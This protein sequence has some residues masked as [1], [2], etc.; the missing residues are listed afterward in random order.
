LSALEPGLLRWPAGHR[1]QEYVWSRGGGGQSG[2]WMLT[3]EHI[4]AFIHLAR[5]TGAEP[6]F[7]INIKRSTP[8]AAADLLHFLHVEHGYG[9]RWLQL[10]NEPDLRDNIFTSPEAY[11]DVL[12]SFASALR[13][14]DPSARF[15]GP[16][17][18]TGAHVGAIHGT[19]DWMTPILSRVGSLFDGI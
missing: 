3:P 18:L 1:S 11:A 5:S 6:L 4:E 8:S 15:V 9:I 19:T 13:A 10:G 12:R 7:G 17:L 16:E 2:D 14:V